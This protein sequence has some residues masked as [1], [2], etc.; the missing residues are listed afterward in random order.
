MS[1]KNIIKVA[2]YYNVKYGFDK[3]AQS[4]DPL[5]TL[6]SQLSP[7]ADQV[8]ASMQVQPDGWKF[9]QDFDLI[10][11]IYTPNAITILNNISAQAG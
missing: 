5:F 2:N 3:S 4:A 6:S 11:N 9:A 8:V 1:L 7:I 10:K